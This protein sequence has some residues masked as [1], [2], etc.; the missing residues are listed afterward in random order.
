MKANNSTRL[1]V[2]FHDKLLYDKL[3]KSTRSPKSKGMQ[4]ETKK[5][6]AERTISNYSQMYEHCVAADEPIAEE[7]T[8]NLAIKAEL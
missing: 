7:V 3:W 5:N 6:L 1:I 8:G 4:H 2:N